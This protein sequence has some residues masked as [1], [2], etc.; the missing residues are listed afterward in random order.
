MLFVCRVSH[1]AKIRF[2]TRTDGEDLYVAAIQHFL[3]VVID[4]GDIIRLAV[5][6]LYG[7]CEDILTAKLAS[8]KQQMLAMDIA[9]LDTKLVTAVQNDR[10]FGLVYK[11][12]PGMG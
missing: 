10:L 6:K 1:C 9:E 11:N 8:S 2:S 5:C 4:A 12:T 7:H 3:R